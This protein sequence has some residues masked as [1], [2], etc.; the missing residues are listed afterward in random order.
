MKTQYQHQWDVGLSMMAD[1]CWCLKCDGKS[2]EE[3]QEKPIDES[4]CLTQLSK[5]PN[6]VKTKLY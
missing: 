3:L 6:L 2:S 1:H 5:K 4:S